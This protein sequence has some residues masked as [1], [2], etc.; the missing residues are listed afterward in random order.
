MALIK[1]I[2]EIRA[3]IPRQS[4][5]SD[6]ANLPNTDKAGRMHI[7][8]LLGKALYADL[9]AKYN[10]VPANLS[11]DE[12]LLIKNVQLPLSAFTLLDDLAFMQTMITDSGIRTARTDSTE[13]AHRWE[14][15]ELQNALMNYAIDGVELLLDYLYS[16]KD[17]WEKWT[18]S[19]EY[20]EIENFLIKTGTDFRKYYPLKQPLRTYWAL[21]PVMQDVEENY[22]V[23]TLGRDLFTW[24]KTQDDII[25]TADGGEVDV[26]KILKR[27][28]AHFT[29]KH[30]GEQCAV[31][32]DENGFTVLAFRGS[33]DSPTSDGKVAASP[34]DLA[35]KLDAANRE[36]QNNLSRAALYLVNIAAGMYNGDF[37]SDFATAFDN[38]PLKPDPAKKKYSNGN[39]R[40]K[41]FRF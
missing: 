28:V 9:D 38:S 39:E 16:T 36:G 32:F 34:A 26:K 27:S 37:G 40:R 29:I 2:A 23:P 14:F 10:A 33:L 17:K 30:A 6:T 11:N 19:A 12:L 1:T 20:K 22:L 4:K 7:L 3:V 13:A 15:K 8:P 18:E 21:R 41:I 24:I 35:T 25:I 31:Q 5:L